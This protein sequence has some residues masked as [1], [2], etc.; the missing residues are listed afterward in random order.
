MRDLSLDADGS[1]NL[2]GGAFDTLSCGSFS[3]GHCGP[4]SSVVSMSVLGVPATRY[5]TQGS[6]IMDNDADTVLRKLP[7]AWEAAEAELIKRVFRNSR[8][9]APKR[10]VTSLWWR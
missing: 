5:E 3:A 8:P 7:Y 9:A 6:L 10:L 4:R 2:R 1:P